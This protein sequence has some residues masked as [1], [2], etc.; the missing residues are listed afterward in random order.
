MRILLGGVELAGWTDN[1]VASLTINGSHVVEPVDI[2]KASRKRVF[3]RGNQLINVSFSVVRLFTTL[4]EAGV[5]ATSGFSY[6]TKKGSLEIQCGLST[7]YQSVYMAG[8]VVSSAPAEWEGRAVKVNYTITAPEATTSTP[9]TVYTGGEAMIQKGSESI[10][11]GVE[12]LDVSF[13][14]PFSAVPVIT[15]EMSHPSGGDIIGRS[16]RQDL[17]TIN[18]FRVEFAYPIPAS[19]YYL[20]WTAIGA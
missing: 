15:L 8:A 7:D 13:G 5:F 4:K 10:T 12:Y 18:G 20:E 14:E 19:G 17:K 2:V 11:S 1:P 6:M 16:L 9:P 3:S